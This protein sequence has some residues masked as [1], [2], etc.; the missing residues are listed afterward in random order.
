MLFTAALAGLVYGLIESNRRSFGD[1]LVLGCLIGAGVLLVAFLVVET[2]ASYASA[3]TVAGVA[4]VA[5]VT[6][7][8]GVV[9][10]GGFAH[11]WQVMMP[12]LSVAAVALME[13]RTFSLMPSVVLVDPNSGTPL[14]S[15]TPVVLYAIP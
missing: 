1:G 6:V 15:G 3:S 14:H 9:P 13:V 2:R 10:W 7:A 4:L 12:V 5:V 11:H 8:A